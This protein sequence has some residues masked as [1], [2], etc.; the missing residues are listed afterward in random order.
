MAHVTLRGN[1]PSSIATPAPASTIPPRSTC[2]RS[3][4]PPRAPLRFRLPPKASPLCSFGIVE[5]RGGKSLALLSR[6]RYG[7]ETDS[8]RPQRNP[9]EPQDC[10]RRCAIEATRGI[11]RK[12]TRSRGS[13]RASVSSM[14]TVRS[15]ICSRPCPARCSISGPG[16]DAMLR[17][18]SGSGIEWWRWNRPPPSAIGRPSYIRPPALNGSRTTFRTWH[19]SR[20]AVT[21]ST[22]SCSR[23]SGHT[24]TCSNDGRRCR[25]SPVSFVP[26]GSC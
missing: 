18:W 16:Q 8:G 11:R 21:G 23:P 20:G 4:A 3:D 24:S 9:D 7:E 13:M 26:A 14:S 12:R 22:S 10:C 17:P 2:R 15:C 1:T 5:S 25:Q 19:V 6:S